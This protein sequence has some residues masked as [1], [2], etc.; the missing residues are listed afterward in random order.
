MKI[1][2][3]AFL[4]AEWDVNVNHKKSPEKISELKCI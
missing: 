1:A 2:V 3:A 4:F